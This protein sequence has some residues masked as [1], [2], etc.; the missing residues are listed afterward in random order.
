M[1]QTFENSPILLHCSSSNCQIPVWIAPPLPQ[2]LPPRSIITPLSKPTRL[3]SVIFLKKSKS[4][5]IIE[6][7]QRKVGQRGPASSRKRFRFLVSRGAASDSRRSIL[8]ESESAPSM[9]PFGGESRRSWWS[10]EDLARFATVARIV[11]ANK[12]L[13]IKWVF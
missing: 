4:S 7:S 10:V 9:S 1:F 11:K 8:E 5:K 3:W 6:N 12:S 2:S 13:K